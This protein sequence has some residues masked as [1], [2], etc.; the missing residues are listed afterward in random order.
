[1]NILTFDIEEWALAKTRG[2]GTPEFYANLDKY[3]QDILD[4]L[5]KREFKATFFCTGMMALEFPEVVKRIK[6]HGHEIG[7]HSHRH[8]WMNKMTETEARED[9]HVAVDALEQCIGQ[10]VLSYRAPAFS[11]GESN[12]W[13]FD[14][15]AENGI[16]MDSSIFPASR[17]F[18][19]FASFGQKNPSII[20]YNGIRLKEFPITTTKVLGKEIAY[21]GGGY[22]RLF[23]Q[24]FV[25][26]QMN[27]M[28]HT[29]CY[30]HIDDLIPEFGG[31]LA[32]AE[33]ESRFKQ[34]GTLKNRYLRYF[35]SNIGKGGAFS[36]LT[37]LLMEYNFHSVGQ[38]EQMINWNEVPH[39]SL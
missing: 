20:E 3:L 15:L 14:I 30:F 18:G 33:Y 22:F 21:S 32:K 29:M 11:I 25:R 7:C 28:N 35:K 26:S 19:G 37:S 39:V 23:P 24:W 4:I 16:V 31:V 1:M 6:N 12:K 10:K 27:Q 38:A 13:M 8:T 34:P 17:D 2:D 36:K 5:E 9:T